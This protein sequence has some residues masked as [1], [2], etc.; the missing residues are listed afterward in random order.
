MSSTALLYTTAGR[1]R[2]KPAFA[3]IRE[4]LVT[5]FLASAERS[6]ERYCD[7]ELNLATR[8]EVYDGTD[9]IYFFLRVAPVTSIAS[10]VV[11]D[12]N[13]DKETLAASDFRFDPANGRVQFGPDN[14][15]SFA[16]W[17]VFP[18]QNITVEY[19]AGH[20]V[21][22]ADMPDDIQEAVILYAIA[23]YAQSSLFMNAGIQQQAIGSGANMK[24]MP[25]DEL[26]KMLEK[27][28]D[29]LNPYRRLE[30]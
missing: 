1:A 22:P 15:S 8:T 29:K 12:R 4:E 7:R 2:R 23:D 16:L 3:G 10:I 30:V 13:G 11:E 19:L 17:P 25:Q 18:L 9:E 20:A 6:V 21:A 24:R 14:Q 26:E 5:D 28:R 27:A